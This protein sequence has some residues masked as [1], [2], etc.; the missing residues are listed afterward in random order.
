MSISA[1]MR[2]LVRERANFRCEYCGV[3]EQDTGGELTLDH[4]QPQ[5]R[6]GT[7]DPA[8]LLYCCQHCNQ[9]KSDYWPDDEASPML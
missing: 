3:S 9:Y 8:N 5:V 6:G 7:D 4:F 2:L 1:E